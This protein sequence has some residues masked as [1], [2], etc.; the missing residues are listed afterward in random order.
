M[1]NAASRSHTGGRP[2]DG[3]AGGHEQ[4]D[5]PDKDKMCHHDNQINCDFWERHF[6]GESRKKGRGYRHK[7]H[8]KI[9]TYINYQLHHSFVKNQTYIHNMIFN[10]R[11]AFVI[12]T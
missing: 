2:I 5:V 8:T 1:L 7:I 12:G 6:T 10:N 9:Q 11:T 4:E 3:M